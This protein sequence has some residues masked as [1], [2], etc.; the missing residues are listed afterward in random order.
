MGIGKL[1]GSVFR[2]GSTEKKENVD[3]VYEYM[4]SF[5]GDFTVGESLNLTAEEYD[6][7]DICQSYDALAEVEATEGYKSAALYANQ[8]PYDMRVR[9]CRLMMQRQ[10]EEEV[11]LLDE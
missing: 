6:T 8:L 2:H 3:A 4:V 11:S 5:F 7:P 10:I 1:L 9:L